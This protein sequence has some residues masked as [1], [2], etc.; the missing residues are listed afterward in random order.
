MKKIEA[1]I[2]PFRLESVMD[3]LGEMVVADADCD[4]VIAAIL[5]A[6]RTGHAG[7]GKI[8]VY[9]IPEAIRIR[10]SQMNEAAI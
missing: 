6:A 9:E 8:F 10:N 2:Q 4:P 7:D 3:A 5:K 1:I